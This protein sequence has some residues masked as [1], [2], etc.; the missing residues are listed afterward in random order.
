M[1]TSALLNKRSRSAESFSFS[2]GNYTVRFA[3]TDAE[4]DDALKLR[5]NIFNLEL[6]EGIESSYI[7]GRDEDEHDARCDHLIAI[8]DRKNEIIGTYR[9]QTLDA[10]GTTD[11]LYCSSE[12]EMAALPLDV[13]TSGIEIG[14]AC[15]AKDH[16][17]TK[18][19]YL[20][21]KGLL[22]SLTTHGKRYLFGCCSLTS[23]D[24]ADGIRSFVALEDM[25]GIHPEFWAPPRSGYE[26]R[27]N[28][29]IALTNGYRLPKLFSAYLR[30]GAKVCSPPALDRFFGTIDFLVIFDMA[31]A[32]D[33]VRRM[34]FR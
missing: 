15:I 5:F 16:R 18:V 1:Q 32:S 28:D 27:I 8:D 11:H 22:H 24:P 29:T 33:L 34:F 2:E 12:F 20:L 26:C 7:T 17:N 30:F 4:I 21:W 31:I 6:G 9:L 13:L 25:G 10:A 3:A 23:Q 14:R 19:L